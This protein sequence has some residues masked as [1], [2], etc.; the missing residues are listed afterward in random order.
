MQVQ[1]M[2]GGGVHYAFEAIGLKATAKRRSP[3][4]A[5]AAPRP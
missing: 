4:C 2:T 1:E 3:C 5:A